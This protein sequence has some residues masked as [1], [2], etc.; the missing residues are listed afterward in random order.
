M[1]DYIYTIGAILPAL[2]VTWYSSN[3]L[4]ERWEEYRILQEQLWECQDDGMGD[5]TF[6][7]AGA[8]KG[9]SPMMD[10]S[11]AELG[12]NMSAYPGMDEFPTDRSAQEAAHIESSNN[13]FEAP[14]QQDLTTGGVQFRSEGENVGFISKAQSFIETNS[15]SLLIGGLLIF[16]GYYLR[17]VLK[18]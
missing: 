6:M 5:G 14:I 4:D 18:S 13:P 11:P 8:F 15:Y 2:I 16:S 9:K 7:E 17:G 3:L 12:I 1:K 10:L